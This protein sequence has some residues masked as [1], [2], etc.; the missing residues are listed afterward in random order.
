MKNLA[1]IALA[2]AVLPSVAFAE[3]PTIILG[4][5]TMTIDTTFHAKV[6]PGTTQTALHLS[7]PHALNIFYLTIDKSTPGVSLRVV[8][9]PKL[10]GNMR[11]SQMAAQYSNATTNYFSGVNGDFYFT[12]GRATDGSSIV[13]TPTN[14][15]IVDG[16]I[17]RTSDGSY[18]F[19][20]DE[21]AVARIGRLNFKE[22]TASCNGASAPFKV[23]NNTSA[24]NAVSLYT[25]RFWGSSNQ[26]DYASNSA[27][28]TAVLA[29]GETFRAGHDYKLRVTG[30]PTFTGDATIPEGGFVINGRGSAKAF[31]QG[32]HIGD[33]V[34]MHAPVLSD[35][36]QIYPLQCV[37]GNPKNVGG[38]ENLNSEGERGDAKD[39]HPRTGIGVSADGNKIV[40]MVIDGRGVSAG[41]TTGMLGDMLIY[42]GAA[43]GVNLDGGG[44]S[45]LYAGALG[46]RNRCS[47]GSERSVSNGIFAVKEGDVN[48][49]EVAEIAFADWRFDCPPM[50][51]Y[52]PRIFAFNAA[53]VMIDTDFKDYTLSCGSE[54]GTISED[55]KSLYS[56]ESGKGVLTVSYGSAKAQLPV[57]IS[58]SAIE[59]VDTTVIL[60]GVQPYNIRL[61]AKVGDNYVRVRSASFDW[62]SSDTEIVTVDAEG[63]AMG[64]ANG[65][66][67]LTGKYKDQTITLNA[68]VQLTPGE[69]AGVAQSVDDWKITK[70]S[71]ST[72]SAS[73]LGSGMRVDYTMGSSVRNA[74][75]WLSYKDDIYSRPVGMRI[76]ASAYG[77]A[78]KSITINFRA[79]NSKS[80]VSVSCP[81]IGAESTDWTIDFGEYLDLTDD[82]IY[83][84]YFSQIAIEPSE[85]AKATGFFDF[86]NIDALYKKGGSGIEELPVGEA[87]VAGNVEWYNLQGIRVAPA[88]LVPG[89]YIRRNGEHSTK[90]V[91]R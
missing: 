57:Y 29:D 3:K 15:T 83:P 35:G 41:V 20:V 27:E 77:A 45:T 68:L 25:S 42:A 85:G 49:K 67:T 54:I 17:Y 46:V 70:S 63:N 30:E 43:E 10:A 21:N 31:V 89:L 26:Q 32:L 19:T 14:A 59:P 6:G 13:G 50:G 88:D 8:N 48:S 55:G 37:S 74:K 44:S 12:S 81:E 22:G 73:P 87:T 38:G 71:V 60:D 75:I 78:P 16:E 79:A 80:P 33:I 62:E 76:N 4:G 61:Q 56:A 39:R 24:D 9:G 7:G 64:I 28:V 36:T 65:T 86:T 51:I 23:V 69:A 66:A 82:G 72:V 58:E 53:G 91:L 40:M 52:T 5:E 90:V 47:D 84:I 18:Q 1:F 34:E 11:V 2:V